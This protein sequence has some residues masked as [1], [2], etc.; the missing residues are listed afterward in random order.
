MAEGKKYVMVVPEVYEM[1]LIKAKPPVNPIASTIKKTQENP[2]TVW[3]LVEISEEERVQLHTEGLNKLRKVKDE[4]NGTVHPL[5]K[6][7][8]DKVKEERMNVETT[9][10]Q[11][12]PE[13]TFKHCVKRTRTNDL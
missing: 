10:T 2:N 4:R 13:K 12:L 6:A 9:F 8:I 3:N 1:L 11:I 5:Q 7:S